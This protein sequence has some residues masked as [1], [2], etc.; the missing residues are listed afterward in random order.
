MGQKTNS[1]LLR[2]GYKKNEWPSKFIEKKNNELSLLVFE[3]FEI[4]NYIYRFFKKYNLI[5]TFCEIKRSINSLEI[6]ILYYIS[7]KSIKLINKINKVQ[8][9]ILIR[10]KKK[11]RFK[12]WGRKFKKI[13]K[14][15]L[16]K[17]KKKKKK[18][19][20]KFGTFFEKVLESLNTF[21]KNNLKIKI[22]L[23]NINKGLSFKIKN[24]H[25]VSFKEF[26]FKLRRYHKAPFFRECFNILSIFTKKRKMSRLL[27]EFIAFQFNGTKRHK[28][29]L[30]FL[31]Q[32][33]ILAIKAKF[34]CVKGVKI[35][36]KGRINGKS[37]S[38]NFII[39]IGKISL[40]TFD[41]IVCYSQSVAF[42]VYGTFG[43]KVWVGEKR[44]CKNVFTAK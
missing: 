18:L 2:L 34:S 14:F 33:L 40:Q 31:N 25:V 20:F 23:Q 19:F 38:K 42:T 12:K 16:W 26:F 36:V 4:K 44:F 17:I 6:F 28:Y 43:V 3:N 13:F 27:A 39:Q 9:V 29:F 37:R 32:A 15:R 35:V 24:K 22:I 8:N 11:K 1:N 41:M 10:K 5:V 7:L 21:I 30:N